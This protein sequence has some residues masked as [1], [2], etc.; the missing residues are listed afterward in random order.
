[1]EIRQEPHQEPRQDAALGGRQDAHDA[2][3]GEW[4]GVVDAAARFGVSPDAIRRRIRRKTLRAERVP[5]ENGGTP[6]YRVWIPAEA[7]EPAP[8]ENGVSTGRQDGRQDP[9][10]GRQEPRQDGRQDGVLTLAAARAEE[11]ARY[12]AALL[13]P[14][15]A[16]L[17]AQAEE[18]GTLRERTL[19][20][21]AQLEQASARIA[22]LEAPPTTNGQAEPPSAPEAE[23]WPEARSWWQKLLWG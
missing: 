1:M 12:S 2:E 8:P 18:I 6:P 14:L 3:A 13:A 16:E 7:S 4:L 19:H 22:E 20:L 23:S 10:S 15:H 17:K 21:Q 9:G 11:M 5:A